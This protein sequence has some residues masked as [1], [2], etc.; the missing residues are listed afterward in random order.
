MV[1]L[2]FNPQYDSEAWSGEPGKG[3]CKIEDSYVGPMGLLTWLEVRLGITAQEQ[4]QD[5]ILATYTKAAQQAAK[6]RSDIFFARSLQLTSLATAEELLRWRDELVLSGWKVNTPVPKGLTSG[7]KAILYGLGEVESILPTGF[8]TTADRW[9]ILLASLEKETALDGFSVKVHAPEDHM[10][11]VHRTVLNQLRRCEIIAGSL[12]NRWDNCVYL[13]DPPNNRHENGHLLSR[14]SP[15]VRYVRS[16]SRAGR[17]R[18]GEI[19]VWCLRH[20]SVRLR[21]ALCAQQKAS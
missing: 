20:G 9:R 18:E 7:A 1:T 16:V 6:R 2:H 19:R 15:L 5:K 21:C 17:R 3:V 10:H 8:R 11:P 13:S 12:K 4:A 14:K